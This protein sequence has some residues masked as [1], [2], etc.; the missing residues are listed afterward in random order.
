MFVILVRSGVIKLHHHFIPLAYF[1]ADDHLL[2]STAL[3]GLRTDDFVCQVLLGAFSSC[4]I[5]LHC[6]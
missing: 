6:A 2:H 5:M 1:Q 3:N 4:L